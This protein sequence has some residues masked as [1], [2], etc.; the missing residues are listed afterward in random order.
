MFRSASQLGVFVVQ[1]PTAATLQ[2][3]ATSAI[4]LDEPTG[5][6][7]QDKPTAA[8]RLVS[9]LASCCFLLPILISQL[10][11]GSLSCTQMNPTNAPLSNSHRSL[12]MSTVHALDTI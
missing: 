4:A 12:V 3:E 11:V 8:E 10:V 2:D 5:A 9:L 7:S 6:T 1:Q